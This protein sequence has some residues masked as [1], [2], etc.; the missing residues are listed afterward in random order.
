[1]QEC[2]AG[3]ERYLLFVAAGGVRDSHEV[4]ALVLVTRDIQHWVDPIAPI[5]PS[6]CE[7]LLKGVNS[8]KE[9]GN[10]V[11][12][13]GGF[14]LFRAIRVAAERTRII[15]IRCSASCPNPV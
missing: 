3:L 7:T 4:A 9:D 12:G 6:E 2:N 10:A 11:Q 1:M 15:L 8:G 14:E 5:S 13:K